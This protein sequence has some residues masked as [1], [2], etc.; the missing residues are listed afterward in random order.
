MGTW[1]YGTELDPDV[2]SFQSS[3]QEYSHICNHSVISLRCEQVV[4]L[5]ATHL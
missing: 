2:Y 3:V 4:P 5:S 1:Y